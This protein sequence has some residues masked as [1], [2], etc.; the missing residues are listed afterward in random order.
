MIK[1]YI[2]IRKLKT[3]I[4]RSPHFTLK[5]IKNI[6]V[7]KESK[8]KSITGK[9]QPSSSVVSHVLISRTLIVL[10]GGTVIL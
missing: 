8:V 9:A 3:E 5:C 4:W 2:Q 1:E 7:C 10:S 6:G